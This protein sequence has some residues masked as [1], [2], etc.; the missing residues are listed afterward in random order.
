M[1]LGG[2][3]HAVSSK[4]RLVVKEMWEILNILGSSERQTF[5]LIHISNIENRQPTTF[6]NFIP[7]NISFFIKKTNKCL[8]NYTILS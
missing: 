5:Q 7:R 6:F 4:K 3:Y 1:L 2:L 8:E